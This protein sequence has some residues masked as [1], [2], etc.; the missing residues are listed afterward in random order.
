M[1]RFVPR[2]SA[3]LLGLGLI[4]AAQSVSAQTIS[5][6][7]P[8]LYTDDRTIA[9]PVSIGNVTGQDI[10]AFLFTVNYDPAV[11]EI[12]SIDA[13]GLLAEGF[14]IVENNTVPGQLTLAGAHVNALVGE[15]SLLYLNA[16]FT[17]KGTTDLDFS[18]FTFNEGQPKAGTSDG[19]ISNVVQVSTEDAT[20]IPERFAL[21]GNYPNP[22]NPTTTIQFD[23]PEAA[24]VRIDIVDMLG[25]QVMTIPAQSYVAGASHR[26]PVDAAQ[27]ASGIYVYRVTAEGISQTHVQTAT[28]T[29]I[30]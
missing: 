8:K 18:S 4:A 15:G 6:S 28:M 2:V 30:K 7:L 5:V 19:V 22:F 24:S 21:D 29:L 12:T 27:L 1:R 25:R 26:V 9:L 13:T 11:I 10:K 16:K 20:G 3:F 17:S 23:L 14:S